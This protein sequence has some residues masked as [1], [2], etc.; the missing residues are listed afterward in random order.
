MTDWSD[1]LC[2]ALDAEEPGLAKACHL[3]PGMDG[4]E[5]EKNLGLLLRWNQ[6]NWLEERFQDLGGSR[7]GSHTDQIPKARHQFRTRLEG[8]MRTVNLTLF[9]QFGQGKVDDDRAAQAYGALFSHFDDD[10]LIVATTNY[11]RSAEAGLEALGKNVD[12][13]FRHRTSRTPTLEPAGL[14]ADREDQT[15]VIHLHG[16]VGWYEQDGTVV[17]YYGDQPYREALGA[18]VV[19]YPD[20]DKDPTA[21]ALVS[22]LWLEFREALE[23]A[24]SVLVIGHSLHDPALVRELNPIGSAKPVLVGA[25]SEEDRQR[26]MELVPQAQPV[27]L[28]FGPELEGAL[29][30]LSSLLA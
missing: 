13:G 15:P 17:D 25:Y 7:A 16:A 28:D 3:A 10:R 30:L 18:P 9:E 21:D 24:S 2:S 12:T 4:E 20:P 6:V 22:L 11:D 23:E 1:A 29:E 27:V 19:L 26:H 5:F 14:V 8:V